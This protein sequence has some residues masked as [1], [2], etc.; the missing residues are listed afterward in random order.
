MPGD[1][2]LSGEAAGHQV[3]H[4]EVDHGFGAVWVGFVVAGQAAVEQQPAVGPLHRPPFRDRSESP[5]PG[6]APDD[7]EVNAEGSGVFDE[8][9]AVTAVDPGFAQA[10]VDGGSLFQEGAASRGLLNAGRGDQNLTI[11]RSLAASS[12]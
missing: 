3:G 11:P 6:G 8:V 5:D 1:G 10:G 2:V 9:F 7:F 12:T 4:R